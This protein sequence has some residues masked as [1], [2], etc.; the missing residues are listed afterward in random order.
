MRKT[1]AASLVDKLQVF[2]LGGDGKIMSDS[3]ARAAVAALNRLLPDQHQ[4]EL[5]V[6]A[7]SR[8]SAALANTSKI[9]GG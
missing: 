4:I 7:G 3:Q 8:F 6:L 2:A 1:D 9:E 5:T